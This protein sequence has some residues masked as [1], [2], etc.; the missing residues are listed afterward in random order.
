MRDAVTIVSVDSALEAERWAS[1]WLGAAWSAAGLGEREPEKTFHLE[2]AGRAST[3]PS[4]DGLAAVAALRRVAATEEWPLLDGTLEILSESQP[5]PQWFEVPAFEPA[6]AWQAVDVW[7]SEH[8]LFIEF[9]GQRPHTLMAQISLAAG[10]LVD[11]LAVLEPGAAET[12][13]RLREPGEVPMPAVESPVDVVLAELA[14]ALRATDMTWPR[15]DDEDFL[16]LRALAWS[17]CRPYLPDFGDWQPMGDAERELLLDG[18][19]PADDTVARSLADLF[20]DYG[21]GYMTSGPLCWSPEQVGLFLDDWLPRKAVLDAEQRAALPDVL[22]RWI[23]YTL[24][25]RTVD[26]VWI[27]PVVDAV[28]VFLPGF[29]EAF[30]DSAAWGPAKQ[31]AAELEARGVDLSDPEAVED[32]MRS[33]NAGRLARRLIE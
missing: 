7:D 27:G 20:L 13:N 22:R 17:R 11:K 4:P 8:V 26:P 31:I 1:S 29:E 32:A 28:D 14:N 33:L 30:D 25:R 21:D 24:E 23:R 15:P 9:A 10:V 19:A 3:R 2:V 12:W 16:D 5:M 18:F 6:R